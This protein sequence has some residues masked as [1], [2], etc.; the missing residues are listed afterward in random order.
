MELKMLT[1]LLKA[2]V[3]EG[4]INALEKDCNVAAFLTKA[5]A[6]RLFGRNDVD[7]WVKEGLITPRLKTAKSSKK[8]IERKQ[9][10][11]VAAAS[12]RITYLPVAE[13]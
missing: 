11:R 10:E 6:Y 1:H 2:A 4:A 13:R 8:Y 5:D 7:R 3:S 12:N 9:L